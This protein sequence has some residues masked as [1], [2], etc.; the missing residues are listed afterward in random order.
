MQ[1]HS[2]GVELVIELQDA[3]DSVHNMRPDEVRQLLLETATV[4]GELLKRDI[5]NPATGVPD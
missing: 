1:L 5:P 3:A 2:R 4:L